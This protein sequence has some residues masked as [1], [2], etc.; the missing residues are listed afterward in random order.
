MNIND[1]NTVSD[2]LAMNDQPVL[3]DGPAPS[4]ELI[5]YIINVMGLE[6]DCNE[7]LDLTIPSSQLEALMAV[8][9]LKPVM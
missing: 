9:E 4:S 8:C 3:V 6:L 7:D 1:I 5:E 2:L